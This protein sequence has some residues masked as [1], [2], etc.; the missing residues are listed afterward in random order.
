MKE[1]ERNVNVDRWTHGNIT[2]RRMEP[3]CPVIWNPR[4]RIYEIHAPVRQ[5][6]QSARALAQTLVVCAVIWSLCELPFELLLCRSPSE[7][8]ACITGK[9]LWL[10][11]GVWA[12]F[13][14]RAARSC[15][16]LCCA[17]SAMAIAV[18][19]DDERRFSTVAMVL[20][21]VE[22]ALKAA[23]FISLVVSTYRQDADR[24]RAGSV[25][26]LSPR[27]GRLH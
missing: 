27:A 16:A 25:R 2:E 19:F 22:C 4:L 18:G 26:P 13:G 1:E 6:Q 21:G 23:A 3:F 20:S 7:G 9:L 8:A 24:Q 14:A 5:P 17:T 10:S 15:F 11:L 12:L